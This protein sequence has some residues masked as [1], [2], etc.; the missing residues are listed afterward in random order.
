ML[1]AFTIDLITY[2]LSSFLHS[3]ALLFFGFAGS[4]YIFTKMTNY[5]SANGG[6]DVDVLYGWRGLFMGTLLGTIGYFG[7]NITKNTM[8]TVMLSLGFI[9]HGYVPAGNETV[10][11][12]DG[13]TCNTIDAETDDV[14]YDYKKFITIQ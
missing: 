9:E 11:M 10:S 2:T 6:W 7:G 14:A 4:M 13:A 1:L 8:N 3:F 5:Y 12:C